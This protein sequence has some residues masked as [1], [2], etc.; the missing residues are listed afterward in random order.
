MYYDAAR[1]NYNVVANVDSANNA[2]IAAD[3]YAIA[4]MWGHWIISVRRTQRCTLSQNAIS[5][6]LSAVM[7][8]QRS[9]VK[10][11]QAVTGDNLPRELASQ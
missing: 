8:Y 4:Q 9:A 10:Y 6:K 7:N 2:G 1:T 3:I 5:P 11:L